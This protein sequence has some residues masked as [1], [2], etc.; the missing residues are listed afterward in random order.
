M[1]MDIETVWKEMEEIGRSKKAANTLF[2][3]FQDKYFD[4]K[5]S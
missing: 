2:T 4:K 3:A 1:N 5:G